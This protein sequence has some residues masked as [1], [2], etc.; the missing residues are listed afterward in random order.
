M[1]SPFYS[2]GF[3][4]CDPSG[5]GGLDSVAPVS[6]DESDRIMFAGGLKTPTLAR[7]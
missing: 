6:H 1:S 5:A 3:A 4:P 2:M 7:V